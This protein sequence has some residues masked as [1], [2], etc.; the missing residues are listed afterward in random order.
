MVLFILG[1]NMGSKTKYTL[2]L[3][4][5]DAE[6]RNYKLLSTEFRYAKDKLEFRCDK[7]H[8]FEA[9]YHNFKKG[10]GCPVCSGTKRLNY[11]E[12]KNYIESFNYILLSNSYKNAKEKLNLS[13]PK[14]HTYQV[15]YDCFKRGQR[16]AQCRGGIRYDLNRVRKM[17]VEAGLIPLFTE[18]I[19]QNQHLEY[20][21]LKH[22]D[23]VQSKT[24]T[25]FYAH[26]RCRL[27]GIEM[28]IRY[29]E[30]VHNWK[31]GI[32]PLVTY[33]RGSIK[34]WK[35]QSLKKYNFK[36]IITNTNDGDIEIHHL[37]RGYTEILEETLSSLGISL[38]AEIKDY[39][40]EELNLIEDKFIQLHN[41]YGFGL[42]LKQS[43]HDAFHIEYGFGNNTYTQ[44][45][46]FASE[47]YNIDLDVIVRK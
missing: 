15:N 20:M 1:G 47:H 13:C 12:V 37:S 31:G 8:E 19:N 38:R 3:I 10:H 17:F 23:I 4:R 45:S 42:P 26:P 22:N 44:F 39:S 40:E 5:S 16:C 14:G 35:F 6:S 2:A 11:N 21:C 27:C 34:E 43:I 46:K 32:T 28:S 36:C 9:V 18:Y 33:L 25:S 7:G 29:G 30:E 41:H 24:L